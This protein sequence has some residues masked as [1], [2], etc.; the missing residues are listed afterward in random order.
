VIQETAEKLWPEES[1]AYRTL[2]KQLPIVMVSP[3]SLSAGDEDRSSRRF[4][5]FGLPM[6]SQRI[7]YRISSCRDDL[8]M[9]GVLSEA[10][11][12]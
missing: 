12:D 10:R 1:G 6:S 4:R 8:E 11:W 2:H 3:R 7:G 5:K 9:G